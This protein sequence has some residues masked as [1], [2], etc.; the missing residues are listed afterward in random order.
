MDLSSILKC[1][2]NRRSN[3]VL[4][5]FFRHEQQQATTKS[6]YCEMREAPVRLTNPGIVSKTR[7]L[8]WRKWNSTEARQFSFAGSRK[9]Q[10]LREA[11]LTHHDE[12]DL[13]I[14]AAVVASVGPSP[15]T[16]WVCTT[17]HIPALSQ[18]MQMASWNGSKYSCGNLRV[19]FLR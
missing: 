15:S 19:T 9:S 6:T 10:I 3:Q 4:N 5:C 17:H 14:V 8:L 11:R 7:K 13:L 12:E 1:A 2:N 18:S 16:G